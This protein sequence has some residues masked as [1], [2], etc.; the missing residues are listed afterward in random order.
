MLKRVL[1]CRRT[2]LSFLVATGLFL[3]P[4]KIQIDA[5]NVSGVGAGCNNL[6][7]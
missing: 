5:S 4:E 6:R 1:I 2:A 3:G 7:N